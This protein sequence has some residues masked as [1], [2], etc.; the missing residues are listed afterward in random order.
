PQPRAGGLALDVEVARLQATF[1]NGLLD[2][3]QQRVGRRV[4][5]GVVDA[6]GGGGVDDVVAFVDR[7]ASNPV[8]LE[9]LD[10]VS[11]RVVRLMTRGTDQLRSEEPSC[12][13]RV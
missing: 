9:L 11:V 5:N 3:G 13:E 7:K 8:R 4:A 10:E 12:R 1:V 2:R 6:I